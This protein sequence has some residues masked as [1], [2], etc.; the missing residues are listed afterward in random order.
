MSRPPFVIVNPPPPPVTKAGASS[1]SRGDAND[2]GKEKPLN[3]K[4][5]LEAHF[6]QQISELKESQAIQLTDRGR[7]HQLEKT[8][9]EQGHDLLNS[10]LKSRM[11]AEQEEA[12]KAA[13]K[14]LSDLQ[15]EKAKEKT[16]LGQQHAQEKAAM[17]RKHME[18]MS[19]LQSEMRKFKEAND[20][21][22]QVHMNQMIKIGQLDADAKKKEAETKD[23][24]R[25][26]RVAKQKLED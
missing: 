13:E 17:E 7:A 3:E 8:V 19:A 24:N 1:S 26:L 11:K 22:E 12:K 21:C 25:M 9:L 2:Q 10:Q 23:V 15:Q 14:A 18:Q 5:R 20:H 6:Q 4:Q 16:A